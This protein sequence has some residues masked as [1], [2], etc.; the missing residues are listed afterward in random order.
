MTRKYLYDTI[1]RNLGTKVQH[2][3]STNMRPHLCNSLPFSKC[4]NKINLFG[5]H[6]NPTSNIRQALRSHFTA[7]ELERQMKIFA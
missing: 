6:T 4:F 7:M 2:D 3:I 1:R 5:C